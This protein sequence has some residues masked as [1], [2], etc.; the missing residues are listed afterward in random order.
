M[1]ISAL[2]FVYNEEVHI[3]ESLKALRPHVDEILIVDLESTDK[4]NEI[5]TRYADAMYIKPW[6][7]CGDGYKEFLR[8][9]SSGDWL[10]WFF[11]DELFPEKTAKALKEIVNMEEYTA[12]SF[13]RQEYMDGVRL[14]PHGTKESP[15]YQNRL[16][17]KC[18]EIFYTE[19]VH[20]EL[21]GEFKCCPMPPEF[22]IEHHKTSKDQEF[23]NIRL[24]I[25]YKYLVWKYG[26]TKVYPYA[27]YVASY[28]KIIR[29]SESK[30]TTGDRRIH[31]G[32]EE[33][34][35]WRD[36]PI[37]SEGKIVD[38]AI[39]EMSDET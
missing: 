16:H 19:L 30:N 38:R 11:P 26:D 13:M 1:K 12:F 23:D 22:F 14:M 8:E 36:F 32:E 5:A 33:W 18:D 20:A 10:L 4:T 9:K 39:K 7:I 15:N 37:L 27:E 21:H 34:W 29:D 2:S 25:W 6:L 17:K 35:R 28:R 24:Y 3:E 31:P